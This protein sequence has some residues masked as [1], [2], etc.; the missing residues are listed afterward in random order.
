MLSTVIFEKLAH[1]TNTS[2]N[3]FQQSCNLSVV[4]QWVACSLIPC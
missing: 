4:V 1:A 2:T 3:M